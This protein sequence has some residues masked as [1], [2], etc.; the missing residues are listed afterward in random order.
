MIMLFHYNSIIET[1]TNPAAFAKKKLID[2][3]SF[4]IFEHIWRHLKQMQTLKQYK[5]QRK[6]I[7]GQE[8]RV[9]YEKVL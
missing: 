7:I 5:P 2:K 4:D 1:K 3:V 9:E 6:E 8:T